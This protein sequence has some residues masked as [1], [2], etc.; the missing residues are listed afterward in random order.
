MRQEL[1]DAVSKGAWIEVPSLGTLIQ[2]FLE[3][4]IWFVEARFH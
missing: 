2:A 1:V 4:S 3:V